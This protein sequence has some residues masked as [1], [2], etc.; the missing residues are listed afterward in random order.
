MWIQEREKVSRSEILKL[1][2]Y[3]S[4]RIKPCIFCPTCLYSDRGTMYV[5]QCVNHC[6]TFRRRKGNVSSSLPYIG[7][8]ADSKLPSPSTCNSQSCLPLKKNLENTLTRIHYLSICV[9]K[10]MS[11]IW[12]AKP[13]EKMGKNK[14]ATNDWKQPLSWIRKEIQQMVEYGYIEIELIF[15]RSFSHYR[16]L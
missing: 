8:N 11:E 9:P 6:V 2:Q 16:L 5:H 12:G 14:E 3:D 10:F 4:W 15:I 7:V 1:V 13:S